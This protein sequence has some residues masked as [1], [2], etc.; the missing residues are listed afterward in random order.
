MGLMRAFFMN[1]RVNPSLIN[2][3]AHSESSGMSKSLQLSPKALNTCD[4]KIGIILLSKKYS[5]LLQLVPIAD[6]AVL[7]K[8]VNH[9]AGLRQVLDE[10]VEAP[11]QVVGHQVEATALGF[12]L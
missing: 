4:V 9:L 12:R 2:S 6:K 1:S 3:D 10:P 8:S 11:H 5:D 7:D